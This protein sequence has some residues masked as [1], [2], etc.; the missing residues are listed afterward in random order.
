[1]PW[2]D[3]DISMSITGVDFERQEFLV[4][5]DLSDSEI[6]SIVD[7]MIWAGIICGLNILFQRLSTP[8]C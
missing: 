1:M 4:S 6:Q 2:T 5:I 8:N 3:I 7:M